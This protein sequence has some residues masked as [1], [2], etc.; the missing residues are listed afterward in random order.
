MWAIP[1]STEMIFAHMAVSTTPGATEFTRMPDGSS[2][3]AM[4]DPVPRPTIEGIRAAV[5]GCSSDNS[6]QTVEREAVHLSSLE[7]TH[8]RGPSGHPTAPIT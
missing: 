2:S 3:I 1:P 6:C 8:D 4:I 7:I 5:R